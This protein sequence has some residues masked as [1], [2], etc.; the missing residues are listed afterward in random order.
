MALLKREA[1]CSVENYKDK[2]GK[3]CQFFWKTGEILTYENKDGNTYQRVKLGMWP[4][5]E[6]FVIP[7]FPK[8]LKKIKENYSEKKND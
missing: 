7:D 1:I 6:Y 3:D 5:Q 8:S 2:S 4:E